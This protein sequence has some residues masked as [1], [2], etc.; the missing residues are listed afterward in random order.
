MKLVNMRVFT[1][2]CRPAGKSAH[3]ST[4]SGAQFLQHGNDRSGFQLRG[5]QPFGAAN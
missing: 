5:E 2:V 4:A 3:R 1:L